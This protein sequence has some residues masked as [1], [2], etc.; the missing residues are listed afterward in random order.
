VRSCSNLVI[1]QT[2]NQEAEKAY[3]AA[4]AQYAEQQAASAAAVSVP[5]TSATQG[6]APVVSE[7][8]DVDFSAPADA[9]EKRKAEEE[10]PVTE[11]SGGK[12]RRL[13]KS[14]IAVIALRLY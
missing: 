4:A 11:N 10:L 1:T 12:K 7:A 14:S 9:K 6:S 5:A 3:A 2:T 13:G 8:M